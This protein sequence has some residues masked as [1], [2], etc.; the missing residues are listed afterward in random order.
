MLILYR[1]HIKNCPHRPKG[2]AWKRCKCPVWIDGTHHGVDVRKG[3]NTSSWEE[4]E[5]RLR[6]MKESPSLAIEQ[7]KS[8]AEACAAYLADSASRHLEPD[9][10]RKQRN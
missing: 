10:I 2:R 6:Q 9:T 4:A 8:I 1:R 3:L 7:P 5:H